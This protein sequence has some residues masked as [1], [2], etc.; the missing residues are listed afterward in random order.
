[1][2]IEKER[3]ERENEWMK[4]PLQCIDFNFELPENS[5]KN[6]VLVYATSEKP[7]ADEVESKK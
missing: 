4:Q 7:K 1:M 2:M 5:T 6:L 3:R